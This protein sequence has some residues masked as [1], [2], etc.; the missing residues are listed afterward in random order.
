[1]TQ[2]RPLPCVKHIAKPVEAVGPQSVE[3]ANQFPPVRAVTP[4][5]PALAAI[6]AQPA[7][8]VQS[9]QS[10]QP[11]TPTTPAQPAQPAPRTPHKLDRIHSIL[12]GMKG[13]PD[14][15]PLKTADII[16]QSLKDNTTIEGE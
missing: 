14:D 12:L 16:M 8:Q 15:R 13:G 9:A 2:S 11:A 4:S 7:L 3:R 10:A 5:P 1:M 6:P